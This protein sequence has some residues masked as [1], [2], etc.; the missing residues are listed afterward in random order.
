MPYEI[1]TRTVNLQPTVSIK[2]STTP[3]RLGPEIDAGFKEL[4]DYL[5]QQG[6]HAAG[7]PFTITHRYEPDAIDIEPGFPV[8]ASAPAGGRIAPSELPGGLVAVTNHYGP[9]EGIAQAYGAI[10]DWLRAEGREPAGSPWEVYWTDPSA[11]PD[12]AKWRT[13]VYWPIR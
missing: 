10:Q 3:D 5:R 12:T 7:P 9:Y 8:D 6:I 13:E 2:V 1:E 4:A 11:E